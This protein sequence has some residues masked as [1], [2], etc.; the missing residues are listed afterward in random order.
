MDG[1][2]QSTDVVGGWIVEIVRDLI[3][4]WRVKNDKGWKGQIKQSNEMGF[5]VRM[6]RCIELDKVSHV[7]KVNATF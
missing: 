3:E 2:E 4:Q 1:A 5:E 6:N 7:G